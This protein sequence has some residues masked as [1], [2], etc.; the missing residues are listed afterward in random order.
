MTP[1]W[2]FDLKTIYTHR[3]S[4]FGIYVSSPH[5]EG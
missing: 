3:T 4:K 5:G 1:S 2:V